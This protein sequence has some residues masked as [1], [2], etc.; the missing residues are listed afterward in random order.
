MQTVRG[1]NEVSYGTTTSNMR[2]HLLTLHPGKLA[3]LTLASEADGPQPKQ[4]R[5]TSFLFI[6]C[7]LVTSERPPQAKMY[8][9]L[10]TNT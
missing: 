4:A 10:H 2:A 6:K 7:V 3:E 5:I 8:N 9:N 1:S